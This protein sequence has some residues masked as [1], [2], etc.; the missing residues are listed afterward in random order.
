M[1]SG[2]ISLKLS[3]CVLN[4]PYRLYGFDASSTSLDISDCICTFKLLDTRSSIT[5]MLKN[6][7]LQL[8]I[9]INAIILYMLVRVYINDISVKHFF[10]VRSYRDLGQSIGNWGSIYFR[11]LDDAVL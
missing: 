4:H 2:S 3:T 5:V 10:F 6:R 1:A 11:K 9:F 8:T 7:F